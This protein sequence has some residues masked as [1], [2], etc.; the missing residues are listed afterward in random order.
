MVSDPEICT[1]LAIKIN[2]V[3]NYLNELLKL[4]ELLLFVI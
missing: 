1:K 2:F 4:S 3:V